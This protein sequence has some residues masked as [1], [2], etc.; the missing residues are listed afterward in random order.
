MP[1]LFGAKVRDAIFGSNPLA[2]D[3]RQSE[4][5]GRTGGEIYA[6]FEI[7]E[8]SDYEGR[9]WDGGVL[10]DVLEAYESRMR[11]RPPVPLGHTSPYPRVLSLRELLKAIR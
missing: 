6:I 2:E 4:Y 10:M 1:L 3:L 8:D 5:P 11:H 7:C 9:E